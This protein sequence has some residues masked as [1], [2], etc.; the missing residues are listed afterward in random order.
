MKAPSAAGVSLAPAAVL[1]AG[2]GVIRET[3][4]DDPLAG[5]SVENLGEAAAGAEAHTTRLRGRDSRAG[6]SASPAL[7]VVL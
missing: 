2:E 7:A 4:R 1:E 5:A 6:L 3:P